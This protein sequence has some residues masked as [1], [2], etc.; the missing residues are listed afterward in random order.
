[1][2]RHALR[3]LVALLFAAGPLCAQEGVRRDPVKKT[4]ALKPLPELAAG[5]YHGFPG[6]L[7]PGGTNERPAAHDEAGRRRAAQIRPLD[8]DGRPNPDGK[9]VLLSIGMSNTSQVSQGFQK[10]FAADREHNPQVT[11][12]NGA[13]GGMTAAATQNPDDGGRGTTY[14]KTVDQRLKEAG[15]T[16]AQVQAVWI[17]QAD[18]GPSSGFPT[19]A[20]TLQAELTRIVQVLAARFPNL[21]LTYLSSRTYGGNAKTRLNPEPYAYESGFAVKWLIEQQLKSDPALNYDAAKGQVKAPWLSW[22]PY[23]WANAAGDR[24]FAA[25]DY[26][27]ADGTHLSPAGQEK[28]GRLLLQFLHADP[29][30]ALW[31]HRPE[32]DGTK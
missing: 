4:A 14:W 21:K 17:K 6:G 18:A 9:I 15:A 5:E 31:F 16:R 1:M 24:P 29:T 20:Q 26:S 19:Y 32:K 27:A 11:F 8:A 10:L 23:L 2:S 3:V 30:A 7:Y 13:V 28:A 22:G 25:G 12:V